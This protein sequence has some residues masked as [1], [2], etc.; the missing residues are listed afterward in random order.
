MADCKAALAALLGR[1]VPNLSPSVTARLQ[2]E[3]EWIKP[4]PGWLASPE[5]Q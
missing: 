1:G 4:V 2:A 5:A 3:W